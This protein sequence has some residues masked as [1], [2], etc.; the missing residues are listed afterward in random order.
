MPARNSREREP[1]NILSPLIDELGFI[2][3]R[4]NA[5]RSELRP[6]ENREQAIK[7]QI[8]QALA[9]LP[10]DAPTVLQGSRYAVDVGP[11]TMERS[12]KNPALLIKKMGSRFWEFV[13]ISIDK[14]SREIPAHEHDSVFQSARTGSRRITVRELAKAA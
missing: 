9:D 10:A 12:V 3:P 13:R 7:A 14:L 11:M 2:Q 4:L 8:R 1:A 6:L 5:L